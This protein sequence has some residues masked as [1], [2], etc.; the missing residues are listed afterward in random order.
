MLWLDLKETYLVGGYFPIAKGATRILVLF[1]FCRE[2]IPAKIAQ[3]MFRFPARR[4]STCTAPGPQP[5]WAEG[6]N[7]GSPPY[8][9]QRWTLPFNFTYRGYTFVFTIL[10]TMVRP[11]I[12]PSRAHNACSYGR[13]IHS[14]GNSPPL[15]LCHRA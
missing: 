15:H 9:K 11:G 2:L 13:T 4:G 14:Y 5:L 3:N 6:H 8:L 10:V 1:S 12:P 7:G